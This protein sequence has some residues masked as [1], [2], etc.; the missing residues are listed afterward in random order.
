MQMAAGAGTAPT[1]PDWARLVWVTALAAATAV[2][3]WHAISAA[4]R[5]RWWYGVRLGMAAGMGVMYVADPAATEA[6]RSPLLSAAVAAVVLSGVLLA[7]GSHVG[8]LN[9]WWPPEIVEGVAAAGTAAV[10]MWPEPV[11]RMM[12]WAAV[13]YLGIEA[14][15]WMCGGWDRIPMFRGLPLSVSETDSPDTR[16][17]CAVAGLSIAALLA[18][19]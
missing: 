13:V 12:S 7:V 4:A 8:V 18:T 3:V 16:I 17:A 19:A 10:A 5:P 2:Q 15:G 14:T 11:G 1:L 9:P 6:G